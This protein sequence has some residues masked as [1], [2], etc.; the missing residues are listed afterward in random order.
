ML[1]MPFDSASV[2]RLPAT[3]CCAS[4]AAATFAEKMPS[5][6]RI[7]SGVPR[8]IAPPTLGSHEPARDFVGCFRIRG[9][10][11]CSTMVSAGDS[12]TMVPSR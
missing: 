3:P 2:P 7:S 12:S 5:H 6:V 9:R 11:A 4:H 8:E 10:W 1:K